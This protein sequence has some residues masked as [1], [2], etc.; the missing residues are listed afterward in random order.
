MEGIAPL[1][2][3]IG[4]CKKVL[5]TPILGFFT[6]GRGFFGLSETA[7]VFKERA[8]LVAVYDL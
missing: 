6:D 2:N 3:P 7:E 5:G 4:Y 1:D 8:A